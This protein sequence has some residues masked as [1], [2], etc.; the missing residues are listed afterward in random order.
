MLASLSPAE[1]VSE[2]GHLS[3]VWCEGCHLADVFR[4]KILNQLAW[5]PQGQRRAHKE[6]TRRS[7][8]IMI[9]DIYHVPGSG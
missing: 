8:V 2:L 4:P 3:Q 7:E 6:I 9:G 1:A 5:G